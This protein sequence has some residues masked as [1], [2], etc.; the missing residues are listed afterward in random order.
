MR[1]TFWNVPSIVDSFQVFGVALQI[2]FILSNSSVLQHKRKIWKYER[3][4]KWP[5]S[6]ISR[7]LH[8]PA[9]YKS[10]QKSSYLQYEYF[11]FL[12]ILKNHFRNVC[13]SQYLAKCS[14]F[15]SKKMEQLYMLKQ[16]N[17]SQT[18]KVICILMF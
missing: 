8:I 1:S 7:T 5:L 17:Q 3:G 14:R 12:I 18:W 13:V 2:S 9:S 11:Y 4:F 10:L 15:T 16:M 6:K